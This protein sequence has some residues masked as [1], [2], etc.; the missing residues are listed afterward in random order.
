MLTARK[1]LS[2]E[3]VHQVGRARIAQ[4][5]LFAL[6]LLRS[7]DTV[8]EIIVIVR[9]VPWERLWKGEINMVCRIALVGSAALALSTVIMAPG[10]AAAKPV[11]GKVSCTLTGKAVIAP[12]LPLTS[13]GNAAKNVKTT[14]TFTGTLSNCIGTQMNTKKGVQIDGGTITAVAKS[15]TAKGQPLGSCAGLASPTA[16][17]VL[18]A[19]ITFT[20]GGV[21]LTNSVANLTV[22]AA[23]V[24]TTVSFPAS[25]PV[26]GGAAF[27][28]QTVT[29]TAV[30]DKS[31]ADLAAV[32]AGGASTT[33]N[34]TGVLGQSTLVIP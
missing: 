23:N 3:A 24:G 21:K 32:C 16:P 14:T 17:T 8:L 9:G 6:T 20:N 27:K 31:T 25:G 30:L 19:K 10:I 34:F 11:T 33:F 2:T 13:P 15:K 29:A 28:G 7:W 5:G 4:H 12:G 1:E 26:S 18:K 22:G